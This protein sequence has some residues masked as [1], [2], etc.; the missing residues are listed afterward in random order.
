MAIQ[1]PCYRFRDHCN[2]PLLDRQA[3]R[4][5]PVLPR[6]SLP[7]YPLVWPML[8]FEFYAFLQVLFPRS[9]SGGELILRWDVGYSWVLLAWIALSLALYRRDEVMDDCGL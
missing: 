5:V 9:V 4:L 3:R 1:R 6:P 7:R 8:V 2:C